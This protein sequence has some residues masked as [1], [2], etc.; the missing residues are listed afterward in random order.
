MRVVVVAIEV[1]DHVEAERS[2]VVDWLSEALGSCEESWSVMDV[3]TDRV[4]WED[5]DEGD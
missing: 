3:S 2:D 1:P 5:I 4:G